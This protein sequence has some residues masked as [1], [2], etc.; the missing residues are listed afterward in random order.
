M[1]DWLLGNRTILRDGH[2]MNI[3]VLNDGTI[4]VECWGPPPEVYGGYLPDRGWRPPPRNPSIDRDPT[5][6]LVYAG[7]RRLSVPSQWFR[8]IDSRLDRAIESSIRKYRR[9]HLRSIAEIEAQ[10]V[11]DRA[12]V[13]S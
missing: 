12:A 10:C 11:V 5:E 4:Q 2:I 1:S 3:D 13:T 8:S 6:S 7:V 9:R